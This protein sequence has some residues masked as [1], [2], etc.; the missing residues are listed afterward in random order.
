MESI[1]CAT[2]KLLPHF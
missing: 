1:T 2:V